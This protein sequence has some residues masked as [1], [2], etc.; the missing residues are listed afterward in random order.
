M[1]SE[2]IASL[3]RYVIVDLMNPA[4]TAASQWLERTLDDSANRRISI[5]EAFLAVDGILSLYINIVK[6]GT[7]YPKT[8]KK[9]L[10]DELPFMATENIL[11]YCVKKGG[12]RQE[13]HEEIRKLSVEAGYAVKAEGKK[14]DLLDKI[15]QDPKF[16]LTKEELDE[17]LSAGNFTGRASRQVEEFLADYVEPTLLRYENEVGVNIEIK[18]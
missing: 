14:N 10:D 11:M 16:N 5:P 8:M 9:H 6:G 1:R 17:I 13:L 7:V 4:F 2:R 18:V 12:D 3:S 15:L